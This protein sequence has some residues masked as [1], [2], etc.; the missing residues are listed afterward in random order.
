MDNFYGGWRVLSQEKIKRGN[1]TYIRCRCECGTEKEVNLKNL[2]SGISTSCGCRRSKQLSARNHKH[3]LRFSKEW[4]AWQSMKNRCY[5]PKVVGYKNYGGRGIT[6]FPEWLDSFEVFYAYIGVAPEGYTLDRIDTGGNY[7]PGNVRWA[8]H[9][10]Q[11][12]N[13]RNNHKIDGVCISEIGKSL[14]GNHGLVSKR[15]NRGWDLDRAVTEPSH[16]KD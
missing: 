2:K 7:E 12:S 8:S 1:C 4:R 9:K 16:A 13:K 5:N 14:G 15:L 11:S 3:G 6:V 10:Q